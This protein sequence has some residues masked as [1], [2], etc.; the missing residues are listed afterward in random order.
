MKNGSVSMEQRG[1][2]AAS[3]HQAHSGQNRLR[4][5]RFL[6]QLDARLGERRRVQ[7]EDSEPAH[8]GC[9]RS[10][11]AADSARIRVRAASFSFRH[12][13]IGRRVS[14]KCVPKTRRNA[15][16]AHCTRVLSDGSLRFQVPAGASNL[17]FEGRISATR[18]LKP[19]RYTV[20][21]TATSTSGK[22]SLPR[23][24]SFTIVAP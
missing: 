12:T 18:K 23:A 22:T 9:Q 17:R 24:R 4:G 10:W 19:G 21:V 1:T 14:G 6:Q 16:K 8:G 5:E 11:A 13:A 2:C 15:G 3:K 20:Q 7:G